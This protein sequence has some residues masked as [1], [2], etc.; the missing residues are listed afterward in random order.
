MDDQS[1]TALPEK[2]QNPV[3]RGAT[4]PNPVHEHAVHEHAVHKQP[5]HEDAVNEQTWAKIC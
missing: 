4:P 5:V 2:A 3:A 1:K